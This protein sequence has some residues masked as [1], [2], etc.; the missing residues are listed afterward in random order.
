[1]NPIYVF[2][3]WIYVPNVHGHTTADKSHKQ[4]GRWVSLIQYECRIS[5]NREDE[6]AA[7]LFF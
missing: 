2:I 6:N 3:K 1:M 4:S 7:E 5:L